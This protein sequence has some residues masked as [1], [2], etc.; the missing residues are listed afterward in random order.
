[1]TVYRLIIEKSI[2]EKILERAMKK[3][4]LDALVVRAYRSTRTPVHRTGCTVALHCC[5]WLRTRHIVAIARAPFGSWVSSVHC[6]LAQG[7][8]V[9]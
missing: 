4:V 9:Q 5:A 3:L 8:S 6:P 2:E 1:M 7:A